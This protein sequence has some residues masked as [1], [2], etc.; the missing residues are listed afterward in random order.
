MNATTRSDC[1]PSALATVGFEKARA[2]IAT[3][4]A[5]VAEVSHIY[6]HAYMHT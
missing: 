1:S 2:V 5:R 3:A 6:I 4:C